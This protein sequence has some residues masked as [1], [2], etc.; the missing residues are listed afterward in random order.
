MRVGAS[1]GRRRR[2]ALGW[3]RAAHSSRGEERRVNASR[4]RIGE[5]VTIPA[6]SFWFVA[7]PPPPAC[8]AVVLLSSPWSSPST[9]GG[10]HPPAALALVTLTHIVGIEGSASHSASQLLS[11]GATTRVA[12][13]RSS[14]SF[15]FYLKLLLLIICYF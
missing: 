1:R 14:S 15:Y 2:S 4:P 3:N 13:I 8:L 11:L 6:F 5:H 12:L 10:P 7:D 9:S